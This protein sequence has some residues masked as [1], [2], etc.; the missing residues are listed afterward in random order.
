MAGSDRGAGVRSALRLSTGRAVCWKRIFSGNSS[1][2][3]H[4]GDAVTAVDSDLAEQVRDDAIA[5]IKAM[6]PALVVES[7]KH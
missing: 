3:K 4:W 6:A 2:V 1:T 7:P 5:A